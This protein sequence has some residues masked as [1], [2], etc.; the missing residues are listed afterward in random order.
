M[1]KITVALIPGGI[2]SE[3]KLGELLIKNIGGGRMAEY[4]FELSSDDMLLPIAGKIGRYPRWSASIWD[5]V[6][7]A[8]S[9]GLYGKERLSK[10]PV[11]M[12]ERVPI[13][14][15]E[16]LRYIRM[17]EI[18]EPARSMFAHRMRHSTVPVIPEQGECAYAHD[19]LD[20]L[21]GYR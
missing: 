15:T 13:Y 1:L 2:G 21:D 14:E 7:R 5:L 17:D 20:F 12:C 19:W 9:K 6:I 8:L 18:H 10:R 11:P 3:N 4:E 16:G